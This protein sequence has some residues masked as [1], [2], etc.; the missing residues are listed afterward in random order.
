MNRKYLAE[1]SCVSL[2]IRIAVNTQCDKEES[3]LHLKFPFL[4]VFTYATTSIVVPL[5]QRHKFWPWNYVAT[6]INFVFLFLHM[7]SSCRSDS[8]SV[9]Q[10]KKYYCKATGMIFILYYNSL[11]MNTLAKTQFYTNIHTYTYTNIIIY[12]SYAIDSNIRIRNAYQKVISMN[13]ST[14]NKAILKQK[15]VIFTF[16]LA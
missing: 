14:D 3:Y 4:C 7:F 13:Q 9:S 1:Q 15:G 5:Y 16:L 2:C 10:N 11:F 12:I 6:S 8:S